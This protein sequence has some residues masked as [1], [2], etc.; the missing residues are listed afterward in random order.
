MDIMKVS[1]LDIEARIAS[2][3]CKGIVLDRKTVMDR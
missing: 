2:K 1:D 3:V